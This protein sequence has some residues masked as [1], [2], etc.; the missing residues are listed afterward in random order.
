MTDKT[1]KF[2]KPIKEICVKIETDED[3]TEALDELKQL[4]AKG[5]FYEHHCFVEVLE[6]LKRKLTLPQETTKAIFR[7]LSSSIHSGASNK[8]SI[9]KRLYQ[10]TNQNKVS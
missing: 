10:F 8:D 2:L 1:E 5:T 4:C 9:I 6:V 7:L 3:C